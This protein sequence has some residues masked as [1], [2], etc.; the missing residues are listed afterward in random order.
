LNAFAWLNRE[1]LI[2]TPAPT[3]ILAAAGVDP[4]PRIRAA[5]AMALG[6]LGFG[7]SPASAAALRP[8][9]ADPDFE[10]RLRAADSLWFDVSIETVVPIFH[11]GL[12]HPSAEIRCSAARG[13]ARCGRAAASALPALFAVVADPDRNV[14]EECHRA[15]ASVAPDSPPVAAELIRLLRSDPNEC[16]RRSAAFAMRWVEGDNVALAVAALA[17]R[18]PLDDAIRRAGAAALECFGSRGRSAIGAML[19]ACADADVRATHELLKAVAAVGGDDASA[20]LT[21]RLTDP[22]SRIRTAALFGLRRLAPNDESTFAAAVAASTDPDPSVRCG[23]AAVLGEISAGPDRLDRPWYC[24]DDPAPATPAQVERCVAA[25]VGMLADSPDAQDSG[26]VTD[27]ITALGRI[28][29]AAGGAVAAVLSWASHVEHRDTVIAAIGNFGPAAAEAIP[30]LME[31]LR[32]DDDWRKRGAAEAL[33]KIGPAAAPAGS[34]LV[35]AL[36]SDLRYVRQSAATALGL[37]GP[38]APAGAVDALSSLV[39][40]DSDSEVREAA[41]PALARLTAPDPA[42]LASY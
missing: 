2:W 30:L 33:G 12:A 18:L 16:I 19:A 6:K 29:S 21:Q 37:I 31:A 10:V 26:I 40:S 20:A 25:L 23:A 42:P 15:L 8:M 4:D 3:E 27:A 22:E 39:V 7:F 11:E 35:D 32:G 34:L 41:A 5:A 14:R 36:R 17:E 28:G 38:P 24:K 1:H 9:L 13:L